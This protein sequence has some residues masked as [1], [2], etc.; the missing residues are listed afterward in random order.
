MD[1]PPYII[2]DN[3][4]I[5]PIERAPRSNPVAD[6]KRGRED[7]PFGIVDRVTLSR[8]GLEKSRQALDVVEPDRQS[9]KP[10]PPPQLTYSPKI[11]R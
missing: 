2:V 3:Q 7:D 5:L 6:G 4:K 1:E 9:P 11:R 8:E 10:T